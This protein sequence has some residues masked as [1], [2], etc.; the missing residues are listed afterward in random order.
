VA[1]AQL[2]QQGESKKYHDARAGLLA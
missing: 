2:L 1:A